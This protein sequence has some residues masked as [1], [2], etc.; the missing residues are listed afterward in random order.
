MNEFNPT[1]ALKEA[2]TPDSRP[3]ELAKR[4]G[5]GACSTAQLL[6]ILIGSGSRGENVVDLCNRILNDH[7]NKL[8]K[9]ARHNYRELM[10]RYKGIGEVKALEILAALELARRC[11]LEEFDESPQISSSLM[12]YNYL[13]QFMS[14]LRHEEM[15]VLLLDRGKHIIHRERISSGGTAMT[16]VDVKMVIKPAIELLADGIIIAHNHP[17]DTARP[18][19]QDDQL[20]EKI[21]QA[22]KTL[23]ILLLD[24]IIVCRGGHYYSYSDKGRL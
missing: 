21:K 19:I 13:S 17:S 20:T 15:W 18:S 1:R 14:H 9:V 12:A 3:R 11:Q 2:I 22:C 4:E 8:Y 6:A 5:C 24:H 10:N 16:A 7:E 23:D